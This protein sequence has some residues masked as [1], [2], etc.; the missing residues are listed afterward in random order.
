MT[1]VKGKKED[2]LIAATEV[3]G[4]KGFYQANIVDIAENAG[5]GKGTIY[6]YFESKNSLFIE[7]VKYNADKFSQ[8]IEQQV[9]AYDTFV[10]KLH[11]FINCHRDIIKENIKSAG[12]LFMNPGDITLTDES[13][14]EV[15][16]FL[17]TVRNRAAKLLKEILDKGN[18]ETLIFENDL[19]VAAD[20][21]LEM[22]NRCCIRGVLSE[23]LNEEI[24]HEN[25]K[26]IDL[27]MY[28]AGSQK[29]VQRNQHIK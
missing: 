21:L 12:I 7:V 20:M 1:R 29:W 8:T 10:E 17:C 24:R 3:F 11:C 25:K 27:F 26:L 15:F 4:S 19:E 14:K 28:G 18:K 22:I 13:R 23:L 16:D 9:R 5:V 6:E 2:I